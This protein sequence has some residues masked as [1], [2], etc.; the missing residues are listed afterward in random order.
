MSRFA[1]T[2]AG[3]PQDRI[4]GSP[5]GAIRWA[6]RR[7]SPRDK[8]DLWFLDPWFLSLFVFPKNSFLPF[9]FPLK[10]EFYIWL[11]PVIHHY[12]GERLLA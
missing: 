8:S 3:K 11:I 5:R 7:F 4:C 9:S 1:S 10:N 2:D 6:T 12:T